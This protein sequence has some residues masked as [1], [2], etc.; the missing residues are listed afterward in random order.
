VLWRWREARWSKSLRFNIVRW[1]SPKK[2]NSE[3]CGLILIETVHEFPQSF[4]YNF[5]VVSR[6]WLLTASFDMFSAGWWSYGPIPRLRELYSTVGVSQYS[7]NV[8]KQTYGLDI[9]NSNLTW[10]YAPLEVIFSI[11]Y[12]FLSAKCIRTV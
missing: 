11:K 2:Q 1:T 4:Q 3:S 5:R 10:N 12:K 7:R 9:L 6:V 8:G